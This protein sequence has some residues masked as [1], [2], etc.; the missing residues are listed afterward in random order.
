MSEKKPSQEDQDLRMVRTHCQ[1]LIEHFDTVQIF[2][3]RHNSS[4]DEDG[5]IS[6][7]D[8]IGNFHARLNQAKEWITHQDECVR[9][10]TR[11]TIDRENQ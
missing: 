2:V 11:R 10:H 7:R 9:E 3:S 5:T 8:G 4:G 1:Q 6:V